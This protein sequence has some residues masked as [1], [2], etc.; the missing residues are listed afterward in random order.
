MKTLVFVNE[1]D[2]EYETT[3]GRVIPVLD[4]GN[5]SEY[6]IT[7]GHIPFEEMEEHVQS[8]NQE[9]GI[10]SEDF[11]ADEMSWRWAIAQESD[12]PDN[13]FELKWLNVTSET[14][15]SFPITLLSVW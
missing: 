5:D 3:D 15:G 13:P 1:S 6:Y 10:D 7:Y 8:L 2:F 9:Y 4:F 11:S 14:E 12:D